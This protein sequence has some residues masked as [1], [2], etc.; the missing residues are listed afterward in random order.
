MSCLIYIDIHL[1]GELNMDLRFPILGNWRLGSLMNQN[2]LFGWV[3]WAN[4]VNRNPIPSLNFGCLHNIRI[5]K[6]VTT[7]FIY[8]M[9]SCPS[10]STN[11]QH[12]LVHFILKPYL[13]SETFSL[14]LLHY[15][16]LW[17]S[18]LLV[19]KLNKLVHLISIL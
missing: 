15:Q 3:A 2:M 14:F 7:L 5:W 12:H 8:F 9:V 19:Q 18:S 6:V 11:N 17:S 4:G 1:D 13:Q 16:T 10:C